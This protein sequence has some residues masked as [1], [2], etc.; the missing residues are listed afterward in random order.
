[1]LRSVAE[2]GDN[3][4]PGFRV[5]YVEESIDAI[6]PR[7]TDPQD[8]IPDLAPL[9]AS[10]GNR[11]H[12]YLVD[13]LGFRP[14][15]VDTN[16]LPA[17]R[18]GGDSLFDIYLMNFGSGDGSYRSEGCLPEQGWCFGYVAME[19]DFHHGGYPSLQI[20]ADVLVSHEY[21]HAIGAA[22]STEVDVKWNEGSAVWAEEKFNPEQE[23]FERLIGVFLRKPWRPFDRSAGSAFDGWAYGTGLW[24][25]FLDERYGE[26]IV[27]N[28]WEGLDASRGE[29]GSFLDVTD[30][31][32]RSD[33]NSSLEEAWVEFSQWNFFTG[34]RSDPSRSY[35]GSEGW[36]EVAQEPLELA[37]DSGNFSVE[38]QAE[39]LSSRYTPIS[40]PDL[41][42]KE[43][44]LWVEVEDGVPVSAT[45]YLWDGTVSAAIPL[46]LVSGVTED[47]VFRVSTKVSWSGT[48]RLVVVVT[49]TVRGAGQ[50]TVRILMREV[51]V[52]PEVDAEMPSPSG[53]AAGGSSQGG[54]FL[55]ACWAALL[56]LRRSGRQRLTLERR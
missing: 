41:G 21:F 18:V 7:D 40:L 5:W 11:V 45:A 2:S 15:L 30:T 49:G 24:V 44:Q 26:S 23:D 32:L 20:A 14:P 38:Q 42:G 37:E 25:W 36:E 6:E 33:Y 31:L 56:F 17:A 55:I 46:E 13:T 10:T 27:V 16:H 9:I 47:G 54:I 53:C 39:G 8:G 34:S 50:R 3:S 1:V 12:Q 52:E 4:G 22:Y 51:V 35:S 29:V 28:I 48:P 43:K 19:N